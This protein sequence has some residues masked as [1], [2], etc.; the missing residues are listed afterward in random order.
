MLTSLGSKATVTVHPGVPCQPVTNANTGNEYELCEFAGS[1]TSLISAAA[2]A[3]A[4]AEIAVVFLGSTACNNT[5]TQSCIEGEGRDRHGIGLP[6]TQLALL[7]A[8]V[9][10][11]PSTIL[12][13]VNGGAIS[14]AW[15]KQHV[16]AV[17]EALYPGERG[18]EAIAN[19]LFGRVSPAGRLPFTVPQED[20]I[21][22]NMLNMDLRAEGGV[23]YQ[24]LQAEPVW[25]FGA[26]VSY[27]TFEWVWHA[28]PAEEQITTLQI[29]A[30]ADAGG[31][32]LPAAI[33]K[34]TGGYKSDAVSLGFVSA[35]ANRTA[36]Y[37]IRALFD[38]DRASLAIGGSATVRL[39]LSS[40][41]LSVV[42]EG[43]ARWLR[44]AEFEVQVGEDNSLA[45][46]KGGGARMRLRLYGEAVRLPSYNWPVQST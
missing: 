30:V 8:V 23:T 20:F 9:Q 19:V 21:Q 37:P 32:D 26:G 18:G 44:P 33:V 10:K 1:N 43:G 29:A 5:L 46:S 13:L 39:R 45:P 36:D 40:Q 12:V 16:P 31:V 3:A 34:N 28:P 38:F 6:A 24:W 27:S 2:E 25:E 15:A 7:Q 4:A 42:E 41:S 14:A 22:R 11:Q 17:V 35:A